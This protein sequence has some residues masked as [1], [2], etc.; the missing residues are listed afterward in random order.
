MVMVA[1]KKSQDQMTEDLSLFLGNN[2]IRFT[3]WYVSE[4]LCLRAKSELV[5]CIGGVLRSL[6]RFT[7]ERHSVGWAAQ[8]SGGFSICQWS[9]KSP[10][11]RTC[12]DNFAGASVFTD[13][14]APKEPLL[15]CLYYCLLHVI[16]PSRHPL[17]TLP[18]TTTYKQW[19][20]HFELGFLLAF[21][22]I[23]FFLLF[24]FPFCFKL[25]IPDTYMSSFEK[26][27]GHLYSLKFQISN[28]FFHIQYLWFELPF[29]KLHAPL[30][31]NK[32]RIQFKKPSFSY[33][34]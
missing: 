9:S 8:A 13:M 17:P 7:V 28:L 3:V 22:G 6:V 26:H 2:T 32:H 23:T 10:A 33:Q 21:M 29:I 12:E 31:E 34:A 25:T 5:F 30:V 4:Y 16:I 15:L 1:N 20:L 27:L 19:A 11:L 18:S 24:L 14:P